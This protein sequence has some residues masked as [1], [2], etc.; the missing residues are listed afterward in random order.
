MSALACEDERSHDPPPTIVLIYCSGFLRVARQSF[1]KARDRVRSIDSKSLGAWLRRNSGTNPST[2]PGGWK[3]IRTPL[4]DAGAGSG[5][6]S[7]KCPGRFL[8]QPEQH[9]SCQLKVHQADEHFVVEAQDLAS[10]DEKRFAIRRDRAAAWAS[11]RRS[12]PWLVSIRL[13][14]WLK[15]DCDRQ[16]LQRHV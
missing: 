16:V 3:C 11:V 14:L 15:T 5:R 2:Y 1:V 8:D 7:A 13:I 9:G 4:T 10:L 12:Q 6:V